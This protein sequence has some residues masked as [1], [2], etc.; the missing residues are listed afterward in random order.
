MCSY[1]RLRLPCQEV[2]IGKEGFEE[3]LS[4]E[5]NGVTGAEAR[6]REE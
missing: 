5:E 4:I 6:M 1:L 2:V 3:R